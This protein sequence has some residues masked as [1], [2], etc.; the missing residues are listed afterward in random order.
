METSTRTRTTASA[1]LSTAEA[2][3]DIFRLREIAAVETS[4]IIQD[5]LRLYIIAALSLL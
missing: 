4:H 3:E 5:K 1:T 2:I